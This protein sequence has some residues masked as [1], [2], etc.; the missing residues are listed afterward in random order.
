MLDLLAELGVDAVSFE[1][2]RGS[3]FPFQVGA[4]VKAMKA[5][6]KPEQKVLFHAHAGNGMENAAVLEALLEG[7]DGYWAGMEKESSTI[8]HASLGEL[9]ANLVR[10]GNPTHGRALPGRASCCR[11]A[12]R[13]TGSTTKPPRPPPGRS[14]AP[15]PTAR[16]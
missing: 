7:A 14:R 2:G 13:C 10:A 4:M 8:G 16:C 9:V 15:T 12:T 1:D 6:L 11:S 5:L 3:Y